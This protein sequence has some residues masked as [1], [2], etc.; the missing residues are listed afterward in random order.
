MDAPTAK[1]SHELASAQL[2]AQMFADDPERHAEMRAIAKATDYAPFFSYMT[3]RDG[4]AGLL[5]ELGRS[6]KIAMAT[7]RGLTVD[8]VLAVFD[9]TEYFDLAVGVLHVENPKPSPDMLELCLSRFGVAPERAMYVGDQPNDARAAMAAGVHF[10]GM[11]P[12]AGVVPNRVE[13][14]HELRDFLAD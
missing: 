2:F 7:N 11:D 4:L 3:P 5:D 12:V 9:L 14:L 8:D 13:T 6:R 10:V 1:R